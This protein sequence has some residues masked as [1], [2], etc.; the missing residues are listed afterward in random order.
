[1]SSYAPVIAAV[2]G[3]DHSLAALEW[4][5]EA[6][7]LRGAEVLAVHVRNAAAARPGPELATPP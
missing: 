6:A 1:M 7:H 2:D 3:S 5:M 4:A